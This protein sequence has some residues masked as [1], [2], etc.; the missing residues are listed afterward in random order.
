MSIGSLV[1]GAIGAIVG[2]LVSW[3]AAWHNDRRNKAWTLRAE[4]RRHQVGRLI[5][6]NDGL[7]TCFFLAITQ[8]EYHLLALGDLE[9]EEQ[10]PGVDDGKSKEI[11]DRKLREIT[12]YNQEVGATEARARAHVAFL[13]SGLI[14]KTLYTKI[15]L[16]LAALIG[17]I[18][19]DAASVKARIAFFKAKYPEVKMSLDEVDALISQ[20]IGRPL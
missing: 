20:E 18:T 5:T 2:S 11:R 16:T 14:P 3:F 6:A 9:S 15:E 1:S 19:A 7:R 13:D 10:A 17:S 12:R 8:M 4:L